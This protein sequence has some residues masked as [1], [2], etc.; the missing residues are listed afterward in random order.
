[1]TMADE[2]CE[3]GAETIRRLAVETPNARALVLAIDHA[4]RR[5]YGLVSTDP[6]AP[7]SELRCERVEIGSCDDVG[8]DLASQSVRMWQ[9][10]P[11]DRVVVSLWGDGPG[12]YR[13][14]EF[15]PPDDP[16]APSAPMGWYIDILILYG[17]L[18]EVR[19]AA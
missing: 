12:A 19:A 18:Q 9:E 5:I 4:S 6:D 3:W 10:S 1:M 13:E 2:M 16:S 7:A 8:P 17:V 14:H 11:D 15:R